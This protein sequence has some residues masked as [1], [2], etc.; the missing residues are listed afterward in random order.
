MVKALAA[1]PGLT[2]AQLRAMVDRHGV[3]VV[4]TVATNPDAPPTLLEY[5]VR[6]KPAVPKVFREVA[7]HPRATASAL[8]VCLADKRARPVAAGHPAL[9]P[10]GIA[11]LL[12]DANWQVVEAAAANPSLP[13]ADSGEEVLLHLTDLTAADEVVPVLQ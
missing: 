5:L 7:R 2:E 1:H 9:P 6:H 4:A 13:S 12:A 10:P 8:L 11:E 3:R